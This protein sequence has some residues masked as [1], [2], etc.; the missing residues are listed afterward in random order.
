MLF[1]WYC[2]KG[3]IEDVKGIKCIQT[4]CKQALKKG[5][6]LTDLD[7]ALK[8]ILKDTLYYVD[9]ETN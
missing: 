9:K 7:V 6:L 5:N 1:Y 3:H 2:Y 4:F 8:N